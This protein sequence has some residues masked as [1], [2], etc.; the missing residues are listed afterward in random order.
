MI[1]TFIRTLL[2]RMGFRD[3]SVDVDHEHRH[4]TI[5]I[6]DNPVLVK[7]QLPVLVEHINHLVQLAARRMNEDALY[8][9]IN[10][11]RRER[12]Q[13][14]VELARAAARKALATKAHI[15][16]PAMNSYER[17][18]VHTALAEHPEVTTESLGQGKERHIVVRTLETAPS[19]ISAA[20][21][22]AS[23][24]L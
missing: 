5:F 23:A 8:C 21:E 12:E 24:T 4:A 18:I 22:D 1:E 10:N 7:E 17:R 15:S 14:L 6:H 9:D 13:L 3:V 20:T 19:P 11:Y 16:L 2:E